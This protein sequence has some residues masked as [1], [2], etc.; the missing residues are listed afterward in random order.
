VARVDWLIVGV[1]WSVLVVHVV[2][3][4]L[5]SRADRR[6]SAA[7]ETLRGWQSPS[8]SPAPV[9]LQARIPRQRTSGAPVEVPIGK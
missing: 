7:L 3:A 1:A 2:R 4:R 5:S 6:F 8:S 9:T